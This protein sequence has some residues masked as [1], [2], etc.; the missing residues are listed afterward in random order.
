M[1][2]VLL[3]V[4]LLLLLHR[5]LRARGRLRLVVREWSLR[6]T[7]RRALL[8][9]PS[10]TLTLLLRRMS[11]RRGR[12]WAVEAGALLHLLLARLAR[13]QLHLR[14]LGRAETLH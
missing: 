11:L 13:E 4:M 5:R 6:L 3:A 8:R 7:L 1:L 12:R 10:L 14:H 2:A 9:Q